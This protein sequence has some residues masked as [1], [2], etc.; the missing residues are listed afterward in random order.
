MTWTA[1]FSALSFSP[2]KRSRPFII[3]RAF[4]SSTEKCLWGVNFI[5]VG[6][7][8]LLHKF[9]HG[10]F[11]VTVSHWQ[12]Y[13]VSFN[14]TEE[15]CSHAVTVFSFFYTSLLFVCFLLCCHKEQSFEISRLLV[16]TFLCRYCNVSLQLCLN[17]SLFFDFFYTFVPKSH[18][19]IELN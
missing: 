6:N 4:I 13:F 16:V 14:V 10:F 9:C 18:F 3:S 2:T 12:M 15:S 8:I 5:E 1:V 11:F 7:W 19:Q 17:Q